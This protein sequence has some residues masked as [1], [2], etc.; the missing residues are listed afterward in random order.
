MDI[1]F[2]C[3]NSKTKNLLKAKTKQCFPYCSSQ[4]SNL[5]PGF[6][7]L[8]CFFLSLM[9]LSSHQSIGMQF[10]HLTSCHPGLREWSRFGSQLSYQAIISFSI[11]IAAL[12][13]GW[14][15]VLHK[16]WVGLPKRISQ[17][18]ILLLYCYTMSWHCELPEHL[19]HFLFVLFLLSPSMTFPNLRFN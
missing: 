5:A 7:L 14:S 2:F 3:L 4:S 13:F 12:V 6:S 18:R 9:R 10:I 1:T 16:T 11:R 8:F 17:I 19:L 15:L